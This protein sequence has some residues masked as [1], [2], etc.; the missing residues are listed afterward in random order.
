M[1]LAETRYRGW[2]QVSVRTGQ[3]VCR[4]KEEEEGGR[5][6]AMSVAIIYGCFTCF[7]LQTWARH[8]D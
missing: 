4:E 6:Q 1:V 3:T 7:S 5:S 2:S 8:G